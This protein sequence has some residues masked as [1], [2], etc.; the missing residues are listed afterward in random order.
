MGG[1][2]GRAFLEE[3]AQEQRV[4]DGKAGPMGR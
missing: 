2:K 4:T 3:E 1:D